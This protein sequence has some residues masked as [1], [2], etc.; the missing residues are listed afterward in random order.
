MI[1]CNERCQLYYRCNC[2]NLNHQC[3]FDMGFYE[4]DDDKDDFLERITY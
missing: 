2:K 4:K 3:T 1:K